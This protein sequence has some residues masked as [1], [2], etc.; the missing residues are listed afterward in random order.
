ME[1][2]HLWIKIRRMSLEKLLTNSQ[3]TMCCLLYC[4]GLFP[5]FWSAWIL[6]HFSSFSLSGFH[7][8]RCN[9]ITLENLWL[10]LLRLC[11]FL[12][13]LCIRQLFDRSSTVRCATFN[14]FFSVRKFCVF[15]FALRHVKRYVHVELWAS[16]SLLVEVAP[17]ILQIDMVWW[18]R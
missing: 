16:S 15:F 14:F 4:S 12:S 11:E 1:E 2:I 10:L 3:T 5:L 17:H 9:V 8:L 18:P 7:Y 13:V 6:F